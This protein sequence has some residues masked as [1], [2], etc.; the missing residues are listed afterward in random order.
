MHFAHLI[1]TN[2]GPFREIKVDFPSVGVSVISGEN[3]SGKSQLLGGLVAGVMGSRAIGVDPAGTG[4]SSIVLGLQHE[5]T[6]EVVRLEVA[7][8][9]KSGAKAEPKATFAPSSLSIA[10]LSHL[11]RS[12]SPRLLLGSRGAKVLRIE[13]RAMAAFERFASTDLVQSQLWQE[14]V[15]G[16]RFETAS[17]SSGEGVLVDIVS[18]FIARIE[19]E[20]MPLLVDDDVFNRLDWNTLRFCS[21]ILDG[22]GQRSQVIVASSNEL[23]APRGLPLLK[24]RRNDENFQG[25]AH[26]VAPSTFPRAI[27]KIAANERKAAFKLGHKF[28][29]PESR[30]CELKEVR[31]GNP[32]GSIG[33]IVDQYVVAFL[34]A[35]TEQVGS[36]YW[37][38]QDE[39]R[40]V[41]GVPLTDS[42]CDEIARIVVEKV[43]KITPPIAPTS[44]KLEFHPITAASGVPLYVV[45]VRVPA[46]HGKYLYATGSE[47]VFVKTDA[48]KMKLSIMQVQQELLLRARAPGLRAK[49]ER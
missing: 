28:R 2:F 1:L 35:G 30:V 18:E 5:S 47:E 34:N 44:L 39:G 45:E 48:G 16:G 23:G 37:G 29:I 9:M 7:A 41:V 22:I 43:G 8:A 15:R 46:A 27:E 14:M 12:D 26:Y 6:Q 13:S 36:I 40:T 33:K 31:G 20:P 38:I 42:Q 25:M 19:C 32:V 24:L 3:G 21:E 4:P 17:R 11:R 10:L 49:K